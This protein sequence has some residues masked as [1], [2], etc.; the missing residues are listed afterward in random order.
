RLRL[1]PPLALL[2]LA[3]SVA[4]CS[5]VGRAA[6]DEGADQAVSPVPPICVPPPPPV[7]GQPPGGGVSPT[8]GRRGASRRA[9]LQAPSSPRTPDRRVP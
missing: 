9:C 1:L 4:A 8:T 7:P 3:L 6:A 5:P 2:G